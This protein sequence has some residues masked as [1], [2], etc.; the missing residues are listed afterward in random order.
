QELME[1][2]EREPRLGLG[3][4]RGHNR[5]VVLA[6][7]LHDSVEQRRLADSRVAANDEGSTTARDLVDQTVEA[8]QLTIPPPEQPPAGPNGLRTNPHST[9]ANPSSFGDDACRAAIV[10]APH[11]HCRLLNRCRE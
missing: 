10:S 2:A 9:H 5:H 4:R 8:L 6:G 1:P 3:A 7:M 11:R